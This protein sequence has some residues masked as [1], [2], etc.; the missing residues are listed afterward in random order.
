MSIVDD[1]SNVSVVER[2]K[3]GGLTA[4]YF[5]YSEIPEI[6]VFV[7]KYLLSSP[8][9]RVLKPFP[10]VVARS[11]EKFS[12]VVF[13]EEQY[14]TFRRIEYLGKCAHF[15]IFAEPPFSVV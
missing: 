6:A 2:E 10:W 13:S 8:C 15:D 5:R 12:M 11:I 14:V 4:K 9:L 1:K 7:R 3:V